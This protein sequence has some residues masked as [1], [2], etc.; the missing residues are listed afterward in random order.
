M[1]VK[2]VIFPEIPEEPAS[3]FTMMRAK[4]K[5]FVVEITYDQPGEEK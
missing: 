3:C 1:V 5:P 4:V 2:Q